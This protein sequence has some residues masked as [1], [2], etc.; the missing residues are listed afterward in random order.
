M[1]NNM[2]KVA[3]IF[4]GIFLLMAG[5]F[6]YFMVVESPVQINSSYNKR[7]D[8]LEEKYI[9]GKI[10]ASDG[11]VLAK[12]VVDRFGNEKREYPFSQL[13]SH[14]VGSVGR[15]KTGLELA[16]NFT[17]LT[18]HTNVM[19]QAVTQMHGD[20]IVADD[21]VST[22]NVELQKVAFDALG[23]KKGA[24]VAIEPST[25]KILAMVSKPCFDPNSIAENW[26]ALVA[27]ES[28]NSAL[29]NR[30]TQGLYAPGSTFKIVTALEYLKEHPEDYEKYYYDCKGKAMFG[31][32]P[33]ACYNNHVHGK[34]NLKESLAHSCNDS[35]ANIGTLLNIKSYTRTSEKLMFNRAIP[36]IIPYKKSSFK[37]SKRDNTNEIAQTAMGQGKTQI[38]PLQSALISAAIA[39]DGNMMTPYLVEDVQTSTGN[40]VRKTKQRILSKC[41]TQKQASILTEYM[42]EVVES[43]TGTALKNNQYLVAGKT[44]SA[45]YD[46]TGASHAWFTGFAPV[47]DPKIAISIIVESSGT[48]SE[49][50]VPIAK[51]VFDKY[52]K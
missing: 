52:L 5:R 51:K 48:G 10:M 34:V 44:G 31:D 36:L 16:E 28:G 33:I 43:G 15:G 19:G 46:S 45:E 20:K 21:I 14:V 35:F 13:F 7:Q 29:L 47:N 18:S 2:F 22:L 39:N 42:E 25:G 8:L 12:T 4:I 23:N 27:D 50:A 26:D 24:V 40:I 9:R 17:M 38:T 41:M 11:T 1:N 6:I 3:Y 49:Y 30:A 37:L 32:R